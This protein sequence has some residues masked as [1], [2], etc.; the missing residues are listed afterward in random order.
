MVQDSLVQYVKNL[1]Q[2]GYDYAAIRT[3]LLNAGYSYNDV[4]VAFRFAG[5][6]PKRI[7]PTKFLIVSFLILL[8]LAGGVLIVLKSFQ[9]P[10]AVLSF[11]LN[12]FSTEVGV[13]QEVVVN[14]DIQNP[15][16]RSVSGL[17]DF[18]V[19]G[20]SGKIA[21]VTESFKMTY[22]ASV[23]VSLKLPANIPSGSYV[24]KAVISYAGRSES[25]FVSFDVV[26]KARLERP[27]DALAEK[28]VERAKEAQLACPGGCDDLNFCT[29]DSCV[30]GVCVYSPVVPCCGNGVCESGESV[31][32]CV[33]DCGE[34]FVST[35]EIRENARALASSNLPKAMEACDTMAQRVLID[36]C[37]NVVS[38]SADSKEPCARI[39]S[40]DIRDSCY[41]P[42][43]YKND[44]SV[45]S[46]ITN[47][48][49]KNS[50]LSLAEINSLKASL[51]QS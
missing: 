27:M 19:D 23:P 51:P 44:F 49:M 1:L 31:S 13:G 21:S 40:D 8:V 25:Q 48:Y 33:L 37:L 16:G 30:N 42:F 38:E 3:A 10:P 17:I 43:S 14:A 4:E 2:Q 7:I 18:S 12:L 45:C 11:S 32:S 36:G 46:E 26:E 5:Y 6:Q 47:S 15:G 35:D 29:V 20:P 24:L 50:C 39:I 34:R 41:I 9:A 22:R 28:P